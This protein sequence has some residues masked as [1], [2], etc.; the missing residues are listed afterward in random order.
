MD[1][2]KVKIIQFGLHGDPK[3]PLVCQ[4][5]ANGHMDEIAIKLGYSN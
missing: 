3:S 4:H 5:E 1:T 2:K